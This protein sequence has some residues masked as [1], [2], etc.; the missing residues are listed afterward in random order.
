VS[1]PKLN[2]KIVTD[3]TLLAAA[4]AEFLGSDDATKEHR[5]SILKL[6]AEL[7]AR[8]SDKAWQV[9]LRLDEADAARMSDLSIALVQWAFLEGL[10]CGGGRS[11]GR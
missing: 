7:R 3:N 1:A 4:I 8:V 11:G 10:R 2:P 6:E 5:R 9:F